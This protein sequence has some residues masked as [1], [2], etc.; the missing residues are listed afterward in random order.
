MLREASAEVFVSELRGRSTPRVGSESEFLEDEICHLLF[1]SGSL[2]VVV[3]ILELGLD[4]LLGILSL[5]GIIHSLIGEDVL[6]VEVLLDNESGGEQVVVVHILD[7][8]LD[9]ALPCD[10]LLAHLVR[11]LSW[12]TLNASDEGVR[13]LS[14]L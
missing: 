9:G 10:S 5:F 12:C 8:G 1:F 7:E 13:E 11:D 6:E 3:S 14:V 4:L 2:G